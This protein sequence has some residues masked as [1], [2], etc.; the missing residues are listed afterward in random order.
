MD[1]TAGKLD[2]ISPSRT[3]AP[4]ERRNAVQMPLSGHRG[5]RGCD[6]SSTL[7]VA[8]VVAHLLEKGDDLGDLALL[9][10][11]GFAVHFQEQG[12]AAFQCVQRALQDVELQSF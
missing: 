10:V 11:H 9:F 1:V 8:D 5:I 3:E 7:D 2:S 4:K 12:R 6:Y